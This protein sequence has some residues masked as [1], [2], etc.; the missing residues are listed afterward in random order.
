VKVCC[1][2]KKKP[3]PRNGKINAKT[4]RPALPSQRLTKHYGVRAVIFSTRFVTK[5]LIMI[6]IHYRNMTIFFFLMFMRHK[7][8][9]SGRF[10][11]DNRVSCVSNP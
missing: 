5:L 3:L 4:H 2:S 6:I 10:T 7:Q 11:P 8:T 1:A 9:Q